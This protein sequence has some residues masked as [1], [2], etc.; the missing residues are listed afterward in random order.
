[1]REV[2]QRDLK[3]RSS[4]EQPG[5]TTRPGYRMKHTIGKISGSVSADVNKQGVVGRGAW[6]AGAHR[7]DLG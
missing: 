1:M 2:R 6:R 5:K 4:T 7:R 3:L